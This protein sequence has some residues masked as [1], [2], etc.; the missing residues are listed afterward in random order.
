MIPTLAADGQ[1]F[2]Q[3]GR[4][5]AAKRQYNHRLR[6]RLPLYN[7]RLADS[8][9]GTGLMDRA[10]TSVFGGQRSHDEKCLASHHHATARQGVVYNSDLSTLLPSRRS[11]GWLPIR[12]QSCRQS[13]EHGSQ[14]ESNP[15]K[16]DF[17]HVLTCLAVR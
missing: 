2:N 5:Q 17:C 15:A 16:R 11:N 1:I 7:H 12:Q 10:A 9:A 14:G 13:S 3:V 4:L 8:Q 6:V